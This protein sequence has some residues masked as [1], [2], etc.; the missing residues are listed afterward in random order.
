M[1]IETQLFVSEHLYLT[2]IDVEAAAPIFARWTEDLDFAQNFFS[3]PPTLMR[4][5]EMKKRL[6]E[7]NKEAARGDTSYF[8]AV[9][10]KEDDAVIGFIHLKWILW[11]N[12]DGVLTVELPERDCLATFGLEA[13]RLAFQFVF[14]ELNLSRIE[15]LVPENRKELNALAEQAG[16]VLEVRQRSR[17]YRRGRYWDMLHYGLLEEEWLA[18]ALEENHE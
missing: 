13:I 12:R 15:M 14:D 6:Q 10:C 7:M 18:A 3:L 11:N 5:D 4:T 2:S 1:S 9:H 17:C 8:L 16:M